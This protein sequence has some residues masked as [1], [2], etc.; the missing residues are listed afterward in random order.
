MTTILT[1]AV[2][3]I[4]LGVED[5]LST[6]ARRTIS[7]VRNLSSGILLLFKERL[8]ELSPAGSDEV[9]L[10][11]NIRPYLHAHTKV[12]VFKGNG[13]KTVDVHDIK[14]RFTSL[15]IEADWIRVDEVIKLRNNIEHYYTTVPASRMKELLSDSFIVIR[16]FITSE[17]KKDPL[18][19]LGAATWEPLLKVSEVHERELEACRL[20]MA[21]INWTK[22]LIELVSKHLRCQSCDS[23]LLKTLD[24]E[25]DFLSLTFECKSCGN[26]S[27]YDDLIEAAIG[28]CFESQAYISATQGGE[29]PVY[30]C[31][32]CNKETFITELNLCVSCNEELAYS[33]CSMCETSLTP[34]EQ[35]FEGLCSYCRYKMD[36]IPHE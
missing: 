14:I 22:P 5:Y 32:H 3:S 36:N 17:L 12:V 21:Q 7:A 18:T 31:Y 29:P 33:E 35:E 23:M 16:D 10:K 11:Q 27:S 8:R 15:G 1:N 13:T 24:P 30:S 6:D 25:E 19:L 4:Q 9:L 28:S 34:E 2:S 20:L 26:E